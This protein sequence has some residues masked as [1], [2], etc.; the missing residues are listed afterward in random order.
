M[1]RL[2]QFAREVVHPTTGGARRKASGPVVI[3]NLGRRCN[4]RCRHCY[5]DSADRS[6]SGELTTAEVLEVMQDLRAFGVPAL[7][8]SGGEPLLRPDIFEIARAAKSMGF[9]VGLS[10]NGTLIDESNIDAICEAEFDYV[11]VS[12]DGIG[13]VHDRIRRMPG[14]YERALSGMRVCRG[15]GVKVG[16]RFTMTR[17]NAADLRALLDLVESERIDK[18]YLSHLNYSGR[19]KVERRRDARLQTTR[20]AM[21]MLFEEA[22][23]CAREGVEREFVTGNNDADGVYFLQWVSRRFPARAADLRRKLV[24]WGGNASGVGVANID[25]LGNVHPDSF[26]WDYSLGN[27]R[28]RKFSSIWSDHRDPLMAGLNASPRP[29]EGRCAR[30]ASLDICNGNTR[31]RALQLTGNPWAE[32]PGCYLSDAE[33]GL[34]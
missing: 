28:E 3:W 14:A 31:I 16:A 10:S 21:D 34:A 4:L 2:T 33:I 23:R 17:D 24:Q 26:W 15:R 18:L 11:G 25:N 27:V 13:D 29:L 1:F 20:T 7:I 9:Y 12:L 22:I 6:Y 8:L 30:C 19:G 32:D 5:T